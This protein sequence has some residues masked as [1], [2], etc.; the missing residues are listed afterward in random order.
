[1]DDDKM[2]PTQLYQLII[3][4]QVANQL[5]TKGDDEACAKRCTQ[6]APV[7]Q[8]ELAAKD[9]QYILSLRKKWGAI[10]YTAANASAEVESRQ[11]C[12]QVTDWV[13]KSYSVDVTSPEI[14]ELFTELVTK[15]ILSSED[16]EALV[17]KSYGLQTITTQDVSNAMA[18]H[19]PGGKI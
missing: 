11:L 7:V 12:L 9:V 16:V 2:T 8:N 14:Q 15:Q 19:R 17:E 13:D 6:I 18:P 3:S 4:D 5:A 1:M 10:R